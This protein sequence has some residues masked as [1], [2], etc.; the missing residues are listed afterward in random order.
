MRWRRA[1]MRKGS[2]ANS[3]SRDLI[4][5]PIFR[6]FAFSPS[7]LF[8]FVLIAK[9]RAAQLEHYSSLSLVC[10]KSIWYIHISTVPETFFPIFA[11]AHRSLSVRSPLAHRVYLTFTVLRSQFT[12]RN[13]M[14][15]RCAQKSSS[16]RL[17]YRFTINST[18]IEIPNSEVERY[19]RNYENKKWACVLNNDRKFIN[20]AYGCRF[21]FSK[22]IQSHWQ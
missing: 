10:C 15:S 22:Y 16:V 2:I 13:T 17:P 19:L 6:V 9:V 12:K 3:N 5:I 21:F 11:F 18:P 20:T 4:V 1:K 8:I 7:Q 14:R